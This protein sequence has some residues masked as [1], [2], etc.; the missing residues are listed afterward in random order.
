MPAAPA[1]REPAVCCVES[2]NSSGVLVPLDTNETLR[3]WPGERRHA[4]RMLESLDNS[5]LAVNSAT[6]SPELTSR[7]K[8]A[9]ASFVG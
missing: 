1:N 8:S 5:D 4:Q 6:C 7:C 3:H 9:K 2:K